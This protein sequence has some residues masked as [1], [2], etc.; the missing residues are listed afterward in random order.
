MIWIDR[1]HVLHHSQWNTWLPTLPVRVGMVRKPTGE[2]AI[3]HNALACHQTSRRKL[4]RTSSVAWA[5]GF[6]DA[7]CKRSAVSSLDK[8]PDAAW[9]RISSHTSDGFCPWSLFMKNIAISRISR[10]FHPILSAFR[11]QRAEGHHRQLPL[12]QILLCATGKR[13]RCVQQSLQ[14]WKTVSA[15]CF[16]NHMHCWLDRNVANQRDPKKN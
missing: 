1:L 5:S 2:R 13:S 3:L 12:H 4:K 7:E 8:R 16:L 14:Y 15:L 11:H 9:W 10:T 6:W